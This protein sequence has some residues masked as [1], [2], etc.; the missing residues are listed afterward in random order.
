MNTTTLKKPKTGGGRPRTPTHGPIE[1]TVRLPQAFSI[2]NHEEFFPIQHLMARLNPRL[3][4]LQAATGRH[5]DGG[6]TVYWGVVFEAGQTIDDET[7]NAALA[8]AGYDFAH[9][10]V[11]ITPEH[12]LAEFI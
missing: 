1:T 2:A 7:L 10:P 8:E 5:V 3:I 12:P 4:V 9:G 6:P 11:T